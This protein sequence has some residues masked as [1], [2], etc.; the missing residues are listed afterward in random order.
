MYL[1]SETFDTTDRSLAAWLLAKKQ[2]LLGTGSK[3]GR[4]VTFCFPCSPAQ[5]ALV[6][7]FHTN[8]LVPVQDFI[9]SL[10]QVQE[11]IRQKWQQER[12]E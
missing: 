10:D 4:F 2:V 7:E 9:R 6:A 1:P 8:G 12:S 5:E 3:D 11:R